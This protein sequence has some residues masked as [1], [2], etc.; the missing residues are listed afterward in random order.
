VETRSLKK[1]TKKITIDMTPLRDK[2]N[3]GLILYN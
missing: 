1:V 2:G 3:V